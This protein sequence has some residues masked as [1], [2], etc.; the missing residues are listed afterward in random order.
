LVYVLTHDEPELLNST[1]PR[2][3]DG[4]Y[5]RP[6]SNAQG[7]HVIF[8]DNMGEVIQRRNVTVL[9]IT[10]EIVKAVEV[11]AKRDSME[12]Y[13]IES[14]HRVIL[15]ESMMAGVQDEEIKEEEDEEEEA[16]SECDHVEFK[17]WS[18]EVWQEP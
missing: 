5:M 14:K 11:L 2:A 16:P 7:G 12:A 13:K 17:D 10:D 6:L 4:I 1:Q 8:N 18:E 15:Y 3:I 9:P